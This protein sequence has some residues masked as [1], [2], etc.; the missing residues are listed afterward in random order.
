MKNWKI[1]RPSRKLDYQ[2]AGLY[3]ILE[4]VGNS[5]KVKLPD[6]IRIHLV[7]S[8]DRLQRASED[9]LPGQTNE[10]LL[11]IQVNDEDE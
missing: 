8:P 7:F 6:T 3:R 10:L 2:M 9:P 4:R 1:E 5:Y 11:P